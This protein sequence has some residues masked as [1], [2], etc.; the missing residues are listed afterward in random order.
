MKI[1]QVGGSFTCFL[2]FNSAARQL[3]V[4]LTWIGLK[5]SASL[6]LI[7]SDSE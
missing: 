2:G 4:I 6:S 5:P 1:A 3:T 7:V